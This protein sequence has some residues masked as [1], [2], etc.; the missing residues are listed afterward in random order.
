MRYSILLVLFLTISFVTD[1]FYAQDQLRI[2]PLGNSLTYGYMSGTEQEGDLVGYRFRLYT[3]LNEAGYNFTFLGHISSGYNIMPP[4]CSKNGSILGVQAYQLADVMETG[5]YYSSNLGNVYI[6]YPPAPYLSVPQYQPDLVLLE[7][8]TNDINHHNTNPSAINDILNAIDSYESTYSTEVLVLV[9]EIINTKDYSGIGSCTSNTEVTTFNNNL[10]TLINTR[11][12]SGD[13][14]IMVNMQC[15]A[16]INYYTQMTDYLH[17]IQAGYNLMGDVWFD[18]ID[19]IH[20]APVISNIT[21]SPVNEGSSFST[22]SL[23]PYVSDDYT[24]DANITWSVNPEPTNLN[25]TINAGRTITVSPKNPD[26]YGTEVVTLVATDKGRYIQK[27]KKSASKAVSFTIN[28]VNDPPVILSQTHPFIILEDHSFQVLL[29][30]LQVQDIDNNPSDLSL[31]ILPGSHYTVDGYTVIPE[32]NFV[33]TLSVNVA[34]SD[35]QSTSSTFQLM[36]DISP[37]NDPPSIIGNA[38]TILKENQSFTVLLNMLEIEDPDNTINQMTL[39][40]LGGSNYTVQGHTIT[41]YPNFMGTLNI[42]LRVMDLEFLSDIYVMRVVVKPFNDPPQFT[43]TPDTIVEINH[44]F[45][46]ECDAYDPNNDPF[47]FLAI[48]IPDFLTFVVTTGILIGTPNADEAGYY[49]VKI[50]ATD[51]KATSDQTFT[52]HVYDPS[53]LPEPEQSELI[54]IFPNPVSSHLNIKMDESVKVETLKILDIFGR[55]IL[56]YEIGS[57]NA[58]L[59][60]VDLSGFNDGTYLLILTGNE[61]TYSRR[62]ILCE[63]PY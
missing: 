2:L 25:V 33:G 36:A 42:N 40:V 27:L 23:D 16:G 17:P 57:E 48:D 41:P 30:D 11:I 22:F 56:S 31:S 54:K 60:E 55:N 3:L 46:Y 12:A 29:S 51:G 53:A 37:I 18:A 59:I 8:G 28:N 38:D 39:Y 35:L 50:G 26:W 20:N 43:T 44:Q 34:V 21:V 24:T 62:F 15:A 5:Y 14:V 63:S 13:K 6:V 7:I 45:L 52:L 4:D 9:A 19:G 10:H 58:G 47:T 1:N 61:V 49:S 32:E